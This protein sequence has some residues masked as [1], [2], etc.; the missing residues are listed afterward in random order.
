MDIRLS[1]SPLT[2]QI[3]SADSTLS[4]SGTSTMQV[5]GASDAGPAY[6]V[7]LSSNSADAQNKINP[8]GKFADPSGKT[9]EAQKSGECQTCKNRTYQD[10]S[11]DAGVSFKAPGHIAPENSAST[12]LSHEQ[13][14]INIAQGEAQRDENKEVVQQSIRM[15]TSVCPECGK[16]YVSGGE[17]NT[18]TVTRA[19]SKNNLEES[20]PLGQ[21]IDIAA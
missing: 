6:I 21:N 19:K 16:T 5:K 18:T 8:N 20:N 4:L 3:P 1:A 14:H 7:N 2:I 12:V 10:G 13:E 9:G 11:D 17:A 15:F